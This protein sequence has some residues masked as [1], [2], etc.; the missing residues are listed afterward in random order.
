MRFNIFVNTLIIGLEKILQFLV[1]YMISNNYTE[2]EFSIYVEYISLVLVLSI[3]YSIGSGV[4]LKELYSKYGDE[5]RDCFFDISKLLFISSLPISLIACIIFSMEVFSLPSGYY[6]ILFIQ[7]IVTAFSA[8]WNINNIINSFLVKRAV[9][10]ILVPK[11]LLISLLFFDL[12]IIDIIY[13]QL[14]FSVI[15]LIF[16]FPR[17]RIKYS[18]KVIFTEAVKYLPHSLGMY[19]IINSDRLMVSALSSDYE[20]IKYTLAT[21]FTNL[22]NLVSILFEVVFI[23]FILTK[24]KA[25]ERKISTIKLLSVPSFIFFAYCLTY[26]FE[27]VYPKYSGDVKYILYINSIAMSF[28][29]IYMLNV[30]KKISSGNGG[31]VVLFSSS[32]AILNLLLNYYFIPEFGALAAS[33]STLLVYGLMAIFT[34]SRKRNRN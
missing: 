6:H 10:L 25:H 33:L 23:K 18:G 29:F 22:L 21:Q 5:Y 30:N 27:I 4:Y 20:L 8:T 14:I 32:F 28:M 19:I 15:S 16:I 11:M 2:R 3:F 13:V 9:Y 34:T 31:S 24:D 26:I 17:F 1:I 12:E 7:S